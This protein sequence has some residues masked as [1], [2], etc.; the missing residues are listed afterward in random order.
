MALQEAPTSETIH[1]QS[2]LP[3]IQP[4]MGF[5]Q[6]LASKRFKNEGVAPVMKVFAV[7]TSYKDGAPGH[8]RVKKTSL[9]MIDLDGN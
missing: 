7:E 8:E 4:T 2:D 3:P 5:V 6:S 9:S 1:E